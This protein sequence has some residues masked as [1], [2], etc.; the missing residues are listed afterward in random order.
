MSENV[1]FVGPRK[2]FLEIKRYEMGNLSHLCVFSQLGESKHDMTHRKCCRV[3]RKGIKMPPYL[4]CC[5]STYKP[6]G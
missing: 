5:L 1:V 2:N 3:A 4:L 6:W